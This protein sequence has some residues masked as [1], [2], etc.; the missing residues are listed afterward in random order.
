M[1][2]LKEYALKNKGA[3]EFFI[4]YALDNW[5]RHIDIE[6]ESWTEGESTDTYGWKPMTNDF[7]RVLTTE[8]EL[9]NPKYPLAKISDETLL[10]EIERRGFYLMPNDTLQAL[11]EKMEKKS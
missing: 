4:K 3:A 11:L 10:G 2:S 5:Q 6:S 1:K 7:L 8:Y 9:C